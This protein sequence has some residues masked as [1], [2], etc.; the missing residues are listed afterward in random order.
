MGDLMNPFNV[1][2]AIVEETWTTADPQR[3]VVAY[4]SE[5]S[6]REFL[7]AS[8]IVA[9]G[10]RSREEAAQGCELPALFLAA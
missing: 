5:S 7:V 6:L 10:Y 8:C 9:T 1:L 4:R 2:Y 3:F